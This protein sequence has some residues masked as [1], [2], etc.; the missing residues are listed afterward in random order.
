M[1]SSLELCPKKAFF[2]LSNPMVWAITQPC[3]SI[4]PGLIGSAVFHHCSY[5]EERCIISG[6]YSRTL[7]ASLSGLHADHVVA[8]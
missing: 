5:A 3:D 7:N 8:K 6:I 2:V 4:N 1:T